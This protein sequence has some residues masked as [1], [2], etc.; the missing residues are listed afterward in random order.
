MR[1]ARARPDLQRFASTGR[2]SRGLGS[3]RASSSE[4]DDTR[5]KRTRRRGKRRQREGE[6]QEEGEKELEEREREKE[7]RK[8]GIGE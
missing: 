4:R 2:A 3:I 1:S 6:E 8:K 5:G 7:Y